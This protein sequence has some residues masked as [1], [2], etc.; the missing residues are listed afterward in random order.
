RMQENILQ[1]FKY[2]Q[3]VKKTADIAL[4]IKGERAGVGGFTIDTLIV[5]GKTLLA[6]A[7]AVTVVACFPASGPVAATIL[8]GFGSA[9]G[10]AV[11]EATFEDDYSGFMPKN[12][13]MNWATGAAFSGAARIAGAALGSVGGKAAATLAKSNA[14]WSRSAQ[15]YAE[16]YIQ[17]MAQHPISGT[18][19]GFK[20]L[21]AE[22]ASETREEF[23]EDALQ[24]I[25]Q[26][27]APS[28]PWLGFAFSLI[29]STTT[30]AKGAFVKGIK[31]KITDSGIEL[32]YDPNNT[33]AARAFL[34]Q[35]GAPPEVLQQ[36]DA[37]GQVDVTQEGVSVAVRPALDITQQVLREKTD[38]KREINDVSGIDQARRQWL[39]RNFPEISEI[40]T[41]SSLEVDQFIQKFNETHEAKREKIFS[42]LGFYIINQTQDGT[43]IAFDGSGRLKKFSNT[44]DFRAEIEEH[45]PDLQKAEH[46]ASVL[47][48]TTQLSL[49]QWQSMST[50]EVVEFI[51]QDIPLTGG[52][53]K[54]IQKKADKMKREHIAQAID[55]R[56]AIAAD[57]QEENSIANDIFRQQFNTKDTSVKLDFDAEI[58]IGDGKVPSHII[59][60]LDNRDYAR[61]VE[62]EIAPWDAL[63]PERQ[64][65]IMNLSGGANLD[66]MMGNFSVIRKSVAENA[67]LYQEIIRHE[68]THYINKIM[69]YRD[70]THQLGQQSNDYFKQGDYRKYLATKFKQQLSWTRDEITAYLTDPSYRD[71]PYELRDN[72][73]AWGGMYTATINDAF[74]RLER[75]KPDAYKELQPLEQEYKA[76]Y[77]TILEDVL[78][79]PQ[80]SLPVDA[81]EM[82]MLTPLEQWPKVSDYLRNTPRL[83]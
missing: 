73:L 59:I 20:H 50:D 55:I 16:K 57:P 69:Q 1:G 44:T 71:N 62:G 17:R 32:T 47:H 12:F 48:K 42:P 61:L 8:G 34:Q 41:L 40:S 23:M 18:A 28:H 52:Q 68:E 82:L 63:T 66:Q 35:R 2:C 9:F 70:E 26:G 58:R 65:Q 11:G 13:A 56:S 51:T 22:I 4:S 43:L 81:H 31:G 7:G 53:L 74:R 21:I 39:G 25:G 46:M 75:E 79:D 24:R 67:E 19:G 15:A 30:A 54:L 60:V 29:P 6:V 5:A 83:L 78:T 64:N 72:V 49:E 77:E 38:V 80:H 3:E 10:S 14:E 27:V 37:I 33:D 45:Y 76:Q 36:F